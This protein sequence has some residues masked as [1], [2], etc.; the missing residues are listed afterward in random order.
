[1]HSDA[2]VARGQ[3]PVNSLMES[4]EVLLAKIALGLASLSNLC[5]QFEFHF[6]FFGNR[7][8]DELGI[9][10]GFFNGARQ[11]RCEQLRRRGPLRATFPRFTPSSKAS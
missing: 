5:E 2:A 6:Q 8:N 10:D 11:W 1:M 4:E 9:A 3:P 7:F